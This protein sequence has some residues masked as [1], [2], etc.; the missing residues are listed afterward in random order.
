[1]IVP[2]NRLIFWSGIVLLPCSLIGALFQTAAASAVT[3]IVLYFLLVIIDGISASNCLREIQVKLPELVRLCKDREGAIELSFTNNNSG[4]KLI[5]VG[6]PLPAEI[7]SPSEDFITSLP[8]GAQ[9]S[10]LTFTCTPKKRGR[11]SINTCHIEGSSSLGLWAMRSAAAV[12]SEIRVYPSLLS[13]QKNLAALFLNRVVWGV[14]SQRQVGQGREFEKL[15]EYI[16]GDS[17]DSIHWKATAKRGKPI[18]KVFQVERTQDV[19]IIIDS[20]RLSA[21]SIKTEPGINNRNTH[22][23]EEILDRF[24]TAALVMGIAAER[25]GDRF[26]FLAFSDRVNTF[27]RAK[28]GRTHYNA[29][30]DI[31][32]NITSDRVNPDFNEMCSFICSRLRRRSLIIF[33]TNLDDPV[34]ADSFARNMDMV[35][36]KHLVLV[37]M[38]KPVEVQPVFSGPDPH[39]ID[40]IYAHLGGHIVWQNLHELSQ[41]LKQRGIGFSLLKSE[42]MCKSLV[43]QYITIK[44]RQLL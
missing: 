5:R 4:T 7:S 38:L 9:N 35:R 8:R 30:R 2:R 37:N 22:Q 21:R 34:I 20:S 44:K 14:H 19:Y 12:H 24:V 39:S 11:Y 28:S 40:D 26:G 36:R 33:L 43:S 1:M 27:M 32:Y 25:Q 13:E 6:L 31:L 17:Y 41:G 18:T 29:C 10:L 23:V 42:K 15:R 3:V 16:H